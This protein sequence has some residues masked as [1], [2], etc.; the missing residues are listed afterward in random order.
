MRHTA[1]IPE[2]SSE[3]GQQ[4]PQHLIRIILKAASSYPSRAR[5]RKSGL[6][7]AKT[8]GT[9]H[10]RVAFH[11]FPNDRPVREADRGQ[12]YLRGLECL[13][14]WLLQAHAPTST[15]L[16]RGTLGPQFLPSQL[17]VPFSSFSIRNLDLRDPVTRTG[18]VSGAEMIRRILYHSAV[19]PRGHVPGLQTIKPLIRLLGVQPCDQYSGRDCRPSKFIARTSFLCP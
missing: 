1:G 10:A 9:R 2:C 7:D 14:T 11:F 4:R 18:G 19:R 6:T 3:G 17:E 12:I 15:Q 16:S 5:P 8:T 13:A